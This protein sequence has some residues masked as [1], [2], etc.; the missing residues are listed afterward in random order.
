MN[1][2]SLVQSLLENTP[3]RAILFGSRVTGEHHFHSDWDIAIT[4]PGRINPILLMQIE[5]AIE[6]A[7]FLQ[8]VDIVDLST[9]SAAL[10]EEIATYL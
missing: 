8:E 9:A 10:H 3:Y 6:K 5:E 2:L 1:P 4:G 7:N